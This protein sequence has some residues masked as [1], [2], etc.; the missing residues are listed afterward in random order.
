MFEFYWLVVLRQLSD[1][2]QVEE[3][4]CSIITQINVSDHFRDKTKMV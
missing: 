3:F 1:C 2:L 4:T